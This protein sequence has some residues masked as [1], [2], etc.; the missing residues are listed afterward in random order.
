MKKFLMFGLVSLF[1]VSLVDST[2]ARDQRRSNGRNR[3][4]GSLYQPSHH[5]ARHF[6][7]GPRFDYRSSRRSYESGTCYRIYWFYDW[8]GCP[9]QQIVYCPCW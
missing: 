9:Y 2:S 4:D 3:N 5:R 7:E 8:Q 1:M 6:S